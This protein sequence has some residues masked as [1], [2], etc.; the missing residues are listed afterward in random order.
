MYMLEGVSRWNMGR[1]K[2]AVDVE[3]A[4]TLRSFDVRLM[5]HLNNLSRRVHGCALVSEFTPPGKPTSKRD[6]RATLIDQS[7]TSPPPLFLRHPPIQRTCISVVRRLC[8]S[9]RRWMCVCMSFLH[10]CVYTGYRRAHSSGIFIGPD[11]Q[12]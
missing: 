11:Q 8:Y 3:G 7:I 9:C 10:L 6:L 5:S 12:R 2:E 4:S 1:A